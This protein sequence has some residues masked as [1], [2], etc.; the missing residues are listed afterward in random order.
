MP[1]IVTNINGSEE[2]VEDGVN[3]FFVEHDAAS[4]ATRLR[5]LRDDP[6]LR[7]QMAARS[8]EI[9]QRYDWDTIAAS[10]EAVYVE[11]DLLSSLKRPT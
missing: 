7:E 9:G 1:L 5:T 11:L 2:L 10:H 3:G 8:A 4:I 6:I